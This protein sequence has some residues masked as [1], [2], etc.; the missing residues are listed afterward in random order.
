MLQVSAIGHIGGDAQV[1]S[2]NGREFITFRIAHTDRW[3][4]DAGQVHESTIWVDCIMNGK[5]AVFNYLKRGTQV[6]VSGSC[7]LRVYS[8]AKDRC[9]KAG[10]TINVRQV[11]LL[12]SK[13]DDIPSRL[14]DAN[15]GHEVEIT[16]HY[17]AA[18]LVRSKKDIEWYP[19]VSRSNERY[20]V[21]RNGWVTPFVEPATE[22]DA[23]H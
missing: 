12:S 5:P 3:T 22:G 15:D 16:K 7:S 18:A 1:Q 14:W 2:A 17:Y 20:I 11:E 9:M 4:D 23:N 13:S 10:L 19:L 21:D 6:Y 8:S